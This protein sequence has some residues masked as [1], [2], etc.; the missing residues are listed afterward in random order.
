M[1][2][3]A[4]A[5]SAI[6]LAAVLLPASLSGQSPAKEVAGKKPLQ[7]EEIFTEAGLTGRMPSQMR[8]SS[9]GKRLTYILQED[10]GERRDLWVVE[11]ATGEKRVLVSYEQLTKL[12]PA[13]EGVLDEREK[14]RLLRYSVA[15]YVWSPDSKQILFTSAGRLYL[16]DLATQ[17]A[18]PLAA[19]KREVGDPKFSPDGK[20]V[21][22]VYEHDLW[23]VPAAGGTEKRLTQGGTELV[24]HGDLDWVYPEEFAVRTGY[25]WSPDS[26]RIAFLELDQQQVPTYPIS[27]LVPVAATVDFQRYPKA[28]DP[29]PRAQVGIVGISAAE[30]GG[31]SVGEVQW[32]DRAAEYVPRFGW[33]DAGR[34]WVLLLDRA[35]QNVELVAFEVADSRSRTLLTERAPDW[36]NITDDMRFLP[37]RQEFLWASERT[38]YNHLYLYGFDGQLKRTVDF[39][40]KTEAYWEVTQVEG[41]DEKAGWVYYTST[42]RN[43]LGSDL[44]RVKL[45]GSGYELLTK[46]QGA[47][48]ITLNPTADAYVDTYSASGRV[49]EIR[50]HHLPSGRT[51]VAHRSK[52]VSDYEMV[53][54]EPV[55]M[56]AADGALVRGLLLRPKE[57]PPRRK[58][59]KVVPRRY[60]VVMYVYGGPHSPTIRDAWGGSRYLF[61]QYLVQHGFVV[62][63]V[64]D[65]ASS[66]LGHKHEAALN[67]NYGPTAL[68]DHR[69]A[70]EWLKKQP[71]VDP[72]RIAIWGWSGGGFSTCF[73]L[74][75]SDLFK[76]GIAVAPVTDWHLYDSIYTERYMG[77]PQQE[78]EAY[79]KTSCVKAAANLSGR[80]LLVHGTADDNVHIQNSEQFIQALIEAGKPYDLWIYPQKTHS[81]RGGKAQLH[82]FRSVTEY[83]KKHL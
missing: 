11:A 36:I 54:P 22:F 24:L 4:T 76:V 42:E 55:E 58:G 27:D 39:Q 38:G 6:L 51:T 69:V 70:V 37:E 46:E 82:L 60:P 68:A 25:Q 72:E 47:H 53:V 56:R 50:V 81:I 9:D 59:G 34:V 20:W 31:A 30:H 74:T 12:A 35:Q 71:F 41:V 19:A 61:H 26:Q 52:T 32:L 79:E 62:M 17:E 43:P 80:L 29:N 2:T 63:Q 64:D 33:I 75:H 28:G 83:L 1:R 18:K 14:E 5:L 23:L 65:R 15:A 3:R 13:Y 8:W 16:Y 45:D 7:L 66:I 57:A 49:P 78:K 67:R 40:V 44:Y 73:G 48:S 77:L 10:E 21:A